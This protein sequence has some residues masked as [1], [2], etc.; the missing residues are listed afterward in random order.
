MRLS[1]AWI[2]AA[3]E[4]SIFIRKRGVLYST[5]LLP[6]LLAVAFSLIVR[7]GGRTHAGIPAAVVPRVLDAFLFFF[8]IGAAMIPVAIASYS[9]VGEKVERSLEPLLATPTTDGE[10]LLGKSIAAF[11]PALASVYVGAAVFMIW[12]DKLTYDTLGY[13]YFPNWGAAA[14]LLLLAPLAAILSIELNVIISA[15]ASDVRTAQQ[16]GSLMF[17]PFGAI[18][19]LG[20]I[21]IL[22]LTAG[23]LLILSAVVAVMDVI[24]FFVSTA[25]FRREEILTKWR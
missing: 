16:L 24:L 13:V 12:G 6:L 5:A 14:T 10:I 7:F 2:I 19:V 9:L 25:T 15:R 23:N 11:L 22:S 18:Y 21:G 4:L 3:K 17:L 20:E 8:V 1:I